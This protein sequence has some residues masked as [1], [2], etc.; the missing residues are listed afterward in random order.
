M[1]TETG[2]D[3]D[4][5]VAVSTVLD[6]LPEEQF[7]QIIEELGTLIEEGFAEEINDTLNALSEIEGGIDNLLKFNSV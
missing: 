3:F 4:N 7:N 1:A 2:I 5:L 6:T